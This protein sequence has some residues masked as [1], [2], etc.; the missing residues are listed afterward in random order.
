M[1]NLK[2]QEIWFVVGSQ[3]IVWIRG[4]GDRGKAWTRNGRV[5]QCKQ[6]HSL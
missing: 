4:S 1:L 6:K 2:E 5:Y 3:L